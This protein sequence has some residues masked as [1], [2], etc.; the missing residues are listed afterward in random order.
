[1]L[2][3]GL[4]GMSSAGLMGLAVRWQTARLPLNWRSAR[5]YGWHLVGLAAFAIVYACSWLPLEMARGGVRA[6]L[7]Y[8]SPA[9]PWNAMMGSWLYLM[10]AGLFYAERDHEALRQQQAAA[11]SAQLLAQQAQ[12]AALRSQVNPHFLF[13]ALHSISALISTDPRKA[14]EA[15]ERLGDLLRYALGADDLVP[16]RDEWRF[17][18]D[19]LSL[20]QLRLGSRLVVSDRLDSGAG[21]CAVPPLI[22]QPLVEN[23][24]RHGISQR[25]EGGRIR[26]AAATDGA[27]LVIRVSDDGS[28]VSG[29]DGLGIGLDVVRRRLNASYGTRARLAVSASGDGFH[30]EIRLPAEGQ[31]A[32]EA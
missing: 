8:A 31:C 1:M 10:V 14:D 29:E 15:I 12:L 17:T 16:L 27:W 28:G 20:E 9:L 7:G 18:M 23:A 22:L 24:V 26:L 13:N 6:A 11:A 30:V 2:V 21:G 32:E 5:F 19:Y 25:P 3:Y 4:V